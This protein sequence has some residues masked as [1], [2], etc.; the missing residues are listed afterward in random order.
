MSH[1][2]PK[3]FLFVAFVFFAYNLQIKPENLEFKENHNRNKIKADQCYESYVIAMTF[4]EKLV[5][6]K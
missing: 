2:T 3:N 6:F 4:I 5:M 1:F